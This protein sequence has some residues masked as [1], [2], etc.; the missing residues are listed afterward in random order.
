MQETELIH[1]WNTAGGT[2][3][4]S[5][6]TGRIELFDETLRD[7]LQNPSVK[8][9]PIE[10]KIRLL[11]LMDRLGIHSADLGLPGAGPRA[12][13][14]VTALTQEILDAGLSVRP[15]CAARTLVAD[16]RPI[17]EISQKVGSAI[18]VY[19]FIGS[20]P[21]RQYTE[22]WTLERML[23]ISEE[24]VA[25]AVG[26][27]LPVAFVTEDTTRAKPETLRALYER[28]ISCGA[29]RICL[30]DTVGHATPR[31]VRALLRFVR[32][33]IVAPL[34]EGVKLDWHGH[35]DRGL[36]I[37]NALAAIEAG[38]DRIHGCAL[39]IGERIGNV[40]MDLLLVNLKLM[41]VHEG[42]LTCL[43]E[44]CQL[45]AA[46]CGLEI[47]HN[48]PVLGR[49]AFRTGTGAHAAAIVKAKAK[50]DHWLADMVYSAIPA[51]VVGRE[52]AIEISPQS[53][54]SNVR[55]WLAQRGYGIADDG[56]CRRILAVAKANDRTLSDD[57][58]RALIVER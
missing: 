40:Q 51:S 4:W 33:E 30:A 42:D 23:K 2:L 9:P 28:A 22:G 15:S 58:I 17:A 41:G 37:A 26:E 31:G 11:N 38:A 29:R 57:E 27:G 16:I 18:E 34:G 36:G 1:D 46:A 12:V 53:G 7:G 48:Y 25:F 47:P 5:R 56:L 52:Q 43:P 35:R 55:Y 24:A 6:F 50:G 14:D 21:V 45:A 19:T 39:G 3:D 8:D 44:Y 13:R 49:D 32:Q 20:S 10:E 54:L